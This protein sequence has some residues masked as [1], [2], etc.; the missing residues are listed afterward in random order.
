[1]LGQQVNLFE[2]KRVVH[3]LSLYLVRMRSFLVFLI[4][5]ERSPEASSIPA[6]YVF[7]IVSVFGRFTREG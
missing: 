6:E 1:M 3:L 5:L 2:L 7:E 4:S